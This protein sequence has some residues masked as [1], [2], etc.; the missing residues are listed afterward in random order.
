MCSCLPSEQRRLCSVEYVLFSRPRIFPHIAQLRWLCH[1]SPRTPRLLAE[2]RKF[3][4]SPPRM[5]A[6]IAYLLQLGT[7]RPRRPSHLMRCAMPAGC[8]PCLS[9]PSILH[10]LTSTIR[11]Y[12]VP[13]LTFQ[14]DR[15]KGMGLLT[16]GGLSDIQP[17]TAGARTIFE[18][19]TASRLNICMDPLKR[20]CGT[21]LMSSSLRQLD[22]FR[23]LFNPTAPQHPRLREH[24]A[25]TAF[26]STRPLPPWWLVLQRAK[27]SFVNVFPR[28][29]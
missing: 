12:C 27:I 15:G 4:P 21:R 29:A 26:Q 16:A 8:L 14:R 22:F 23:A 18:R 13:R 20:I 17:S 2:L 28:L 19:D 3:C 10:T 6:V 24:F 1:S 25:V 7:S 9:P 5:P 11:A